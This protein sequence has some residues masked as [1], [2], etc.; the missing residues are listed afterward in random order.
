MSKDPTVT[1]DGAKVA[2]AIITRLPNA[3]QTR[4]VESIRVLNPTSAI[5]IEAIISHVY[6]GNKRSA[7][8]RLETAPVKNTLRER[9]LARVTTAIEETVAPL[10]PMA[11]DKAQVRIVK[12][13]EDLTNTEGAQDSSLGL[14]PHALESLEAA[15]A[16][17]IRELDELYSEAQGDNHSALGKIKRLRGRVA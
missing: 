12:A 17:I 3:T 16:K 5:K 13:I 1:I 14:E 9:D 7:T 11:E 10:A 2:A 8:K 6:P 15:Q 4:L